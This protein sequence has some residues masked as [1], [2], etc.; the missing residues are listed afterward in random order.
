[1]NKKLLLVLAVLTFSSLACNLSFNIPTIKTGPEKTEKI[2]ESLPDNQDE[3]Q[4]EITIGAAE[5]NVTGGAKDLVNGMVKYNVPAW[6]PS[7]T[8]EDNN[9]TLKQKET[10][11][12]GL[13]GKQLVNK[14]DIQFTNERPLS[15][16]LNAGAYQGDIDLGGM[17]VTQLDVNDGASN[18]K[19]DF[20]EPNTGSWNPLTIIPVPLL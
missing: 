16:N 17:N 6:K 19:I 4:V 18:T 12:N 7:L 8:F 5:L 2:K 9:F 15:I 13:P 1:M 11:F 3:I 20:S 10:D 14:W